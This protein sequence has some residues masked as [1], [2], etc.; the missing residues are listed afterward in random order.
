MKANYNKSFLGLAPINIPQNNSFN[1]NQFIYSQNPVNQSSQMNL[2]GSKTLDSQ[3]K[4][5]LL[6]T[7]IKELKENTEN[8]YSM[9]SQLNSGGF[10]SSW[11]NTFNN[12]INQ[13]YFRN[14]YNYQDYIY[15]NHQYSYNIPQLNNINE[16]KENTLQSKPMIDM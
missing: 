7:E 11:N 1:R 6:N 16:T 15:Q 4:L 8:N 14:N 5:H 12:Q 2:V 10:M 13:Y 9:N 3:Q